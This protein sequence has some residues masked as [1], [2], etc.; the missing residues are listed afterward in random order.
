MTIWNTKLCLTLA[1]SAILTFLSILAK[2]QA[3]YCQWNKMLHPSIKAKLQK[4]GV[5]F[6]HPFICQRH[7]IN[8]K[9]TKTT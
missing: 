4:E 2:K 7:F 8:E 1:V 5:F 9:E 6:P 3:K